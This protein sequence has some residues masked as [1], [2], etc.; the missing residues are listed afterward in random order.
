MYVYLS[1]CGS[2]WCGKVS[3]GIPSQSVI[4]TAS[5]GWT[6]NCMQVYTRSST[7]CM[8]IY[9]YIYNMY[10]HV[11]QLHVHVYI[12]TRVTCIYIHVYVHDTVH[13][14]TGALE[15]IILI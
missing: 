6:F 1:V 7:T 14:H 11:Y 12:L 5:T 15:F 4:V 10:T 2:I 8:Y 9:M 3:W 13:M